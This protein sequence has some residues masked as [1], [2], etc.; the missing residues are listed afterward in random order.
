M[1]KTAVVEG[2]ATL[3]MSLWAQRYLTPQELAQVAGSVDPA[4]QAVLDRMP[5]ILKDPL[6]FPYLSGLQLA[7]GRF[8]SGGFDAVNGLFADPPESTE[9]VLHP[10]KLQADEQPVAVTFPADLAT[11]L[12]E[13]W[14][15]SMQDTLG[16]LMLEIVLRDGGA[17]GT[18]D[19]AA[20]WGGDRVALVEGPGGKVGVVLDT[21]WDTEADAAEFEQALGPLVTRLQGLGRSASVLHPAPERV[22]LV[23]GESTDTMGR[24]ANV[25]GL[26]G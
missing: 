4:S 6:T 7:L 13:G 16:E 19:A 10:D 20:G 1:A 12:G 17:T 25:L 23:V 9:Q 8:T 21:A 15:V 18:G 24:L 3:L 26:A 5:A 2:D 11:R 22:V 14:K